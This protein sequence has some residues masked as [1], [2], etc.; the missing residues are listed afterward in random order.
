MDIDVL[1]SYDGDWLADPDRKVRGACLVVALVACDKQLSIQTRAQGIDKIIPVS[2][3][4][5]DR[6]PFSAV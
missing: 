1:G 4:G 3:A 5:H 2:N 6:S